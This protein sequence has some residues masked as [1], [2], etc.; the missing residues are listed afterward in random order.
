M[1]AKPVFL[2]V[3]N[4]FGVGTLR[5]GGDASGDERLPKSVR[6]IALRGCSRGYLYRAIAD[7]LN[8]RCVVR[9]TATTEEHLIDSVV[10]R[11]VRS[12]KCVKDMHWRGYQQY[13]E[14]EKTKHCLLNIYK[15]FP[16]SGSDSKFISS[17][18]WTRNG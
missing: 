15:G 18:G 5:C 1:V 6:V 9:P 16:S 8:H 4:R 11:T 17:W 10:F 2:L 13:G 14:H 7:N 12:S 3:G